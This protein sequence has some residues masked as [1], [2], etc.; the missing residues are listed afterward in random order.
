MRYLLA[1]LSVIAVTPAAHA[2]PRP[3]PAP[4]YVNGLRVSLRVTGPDANG[5][6]I[7]V[8]NETF[9][10]AGA[11]IDPGS[12]LWVILDL[13][14]GGNRLTVT[15]T[16]RGPLLDEPKPGWGMRELCGDAL[17]AAAMFGASEPPRGAAPPPGY[18]Q[19]AYAQPGAPV[20]RRLGLDVMGRAANPEKIERCHNVF[21]ERGIMV[22]P[23][24]PVH[25]QLQLDGDTNRIR[26]MA[27]GRVASDE[28]R[29]GWGME[30]L[31]AD[32]AAAGLAVLQR[33]AGGP[34]PPAYGQP[35]YGQPQPGYAKPPPGYQPAPTYAPP[36]QQQPAYA[37]P[38]PQQQPTYAP[39]PP[40]NPAEAGRA[41]HDAASRALAA[42]R[43]DEAIH[44][45]EE[46]WRVDPRPQFLYNLGLVLVRRG[47]AR[48]DLD[49]LRQARNYF[50]RFDEAT[51]SPQAAEALRSIE[52]LIHR[53]GGQ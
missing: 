3:R 34:P 19:P 35:G 40:A 22:D 18:R 6:K 5:D 30:R 29:P 17:A 41:H 16:A 20:G 52:D 23:S 33:S 21:R 47:E 51:H 37:P 26:V 44:E 14:G 9:A 32:A 36:P 39:P 31:C 49:D 53:Y 42:N 15:S 8:C 10:R 7:N 13:R 24:S 45:W 48:H 11:S 38:P 50:R 27:W 4:Q 12:T 28:P 43:L 1:A 25:A 2:D 46:A